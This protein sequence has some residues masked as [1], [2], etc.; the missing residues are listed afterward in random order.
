MPSRLLGPAAAGAASRPSPGRPHELWQTAQQLLERDLIRPI[1]DQA[2]RTPD[3]IEGTLTLGL[4][5]LSRVFHTQGLLLGRKLSQGAA[6][7]DVDGLSQ[8]PQDGIKQFIA[9]AGRMQG[10]AAEICRQRESAI[11][12]AIECQVVSPASSPRLLGSP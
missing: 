1:I 3:R 7:M 5:E 4:A 6:T 2:L 11:A 9:L 12:G 10:M 8:V